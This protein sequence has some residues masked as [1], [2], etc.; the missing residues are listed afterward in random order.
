MQ[1]IYPL[2]SNYL[3]KYDPDNCIKALL[4][5]KS[6][7]SSL[8]KCF[9][10][11]IK[12]YTTIKVNENNCNPV[13][14]TEYSNNCISSIINDFI[15]NKEIN[16]NK[17]CQ[18]IDND[19]N[20][21][22]N[23]NTSLNSDIKLH[24]C[25]TA[26]KLLDELR[27]EMND[28]II[29]KRFNLK[30]MI[31]EY[32]K[33]VSEL[34]LL[35]NK[36]NYSSYDS[37]INA[38][39]IF[40][41]CELLNTYNLLPWE[42]S[43]LMAEEIFY[44]FNMRN[45]NANGND[46]MNRSLIIYSIL[47]Y[48]LGKN[49]FNPGENKNLYDDR[50]ALCNNIIKFLSKSKYINTYCST[51][52]ALNALEISGET[53]IENLLQTPWEKSWYWSNLEGSFVYFAKKNMTNDLNMNDAVT[54]FSKMAG[55]ALNK[56][57]EKILFEFC[58]YFY[59]YSYKAPDMKIYDLLSSIIT[60][61]SSISAHEAEE[62][63]SKRI[64]DLEATI[65]TIDTYIAIIGKLDID[66]AT[67]VY[68][69]LTELSNK[70]KII[71]SN[72]KEIKSNAETS[73]ISIKESNILELVESCIEDGLDKPFIIT[74]SQINKYPEFIPFISVFANRYPDA[75]N[76]DEIKTSISNRISTLSESMYDK[77]NLN[78]DAIQE[79]NIT[80]PILETLSKDPAEFN[81]TN[82]DTLTTKFTMFKEDSL[83]L[84][85]I[86]SFMEDK[87]DYGYEDDDD[88][89]SDDAYDTDEKKDKKDHDVLSK[90][91]QEAR[92]KKLLDFKQSL[93]SRIKS[94][95]TNVGD[96]IISLKNKFNA[97][98]PKVVDGLISILS[99]GN[100]EKEIY[101]RNTILPRIR[102]LFEV[103]IG[104]TMLYTYPLLSIIYLVSRIATDPK[105]SSNARKIIKDELEAENTIISRKLVE[106]K[107]NNDYKSQKKL[108]VLQKSYER[109]IAK[110]DTVEN[111]YDE[112]A[113]LLK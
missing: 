89:D 11:A 79:C 5:W 104:A 62:D 39:L 33:M 53:E 32:T 113:I 55:T 103:V 83:L 22:E 100:K 2:Y 36:N 42:K 68:D 65:C 4:Y 73:N 81:D 106:A 110:I 20:E 43:S 97:N 60:N 28:K 91:K 101:I 75:I 59:I 47:I 30:S 50:N 93:M 102:V 46:S 92:K 88:D 31:N 61:I 85:D 41:M 23:N 3:E 64:P 69:Q 13:G 54:I 94:S 84:K 38:P 82:I 87:I 52:E 44:V 105:M 15:R 95:I 109:E 86:I 45:T 58:T 37:S 14:L 71:L 74:E 24:L 76:R 66:N 63:I 12:V 98:A 70:L 35:K 80:K 90:E 111:K 34:P 1:P 6:Y 40:S 57:I 112:S 9:D 108:L 99:L 96:N 17:L 7:D 18:I 29:S 21:I 16:I 78:I 72:R 56:L 51:S 10:Q 27:V 26:S 107:G 77:D 48:I 8:E 49:V 25:R 19:V 67:D